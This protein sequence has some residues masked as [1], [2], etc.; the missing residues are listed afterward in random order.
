MQKLTRS[1]GC[2]WLWFAT[3][4]NPNGNISPCCVTTLQIQDFASI[5]EKNLWI[6]G[7]MT[8]L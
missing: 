1:S 8:N 5:D 2:D 6:F 7:I 4:I 3:C